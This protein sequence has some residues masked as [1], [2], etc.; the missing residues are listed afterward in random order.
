LAV[1]DL[2]VGIGISRAQG[3]NL[4]GLRESLTAAADAGLDFVSFGDHVSFHTGAGTD[5]L[6]TATALAMLHPTPTPPIPI[7]VGGRSD[8]AVRRAGRFAEG[9]LG[10]WSSPRRFAEAVAL[11]EATAAAAGRQDVAWQHG[12]QFWCGIDDSRESARARLAAAMQHSY[13]LPFE[14]FERYCPYGRPAD[15]AEYLAL[16]LESGCTRFNLGPI[17]PDPA[18]AI[19]G[20]AEVKRLLVGG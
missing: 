16:Y 8:A 19:A 6:I 1:V 2:Q 20:A 17:A 9:W 13:Q 18:T 14:R 15:L 5:G 3:G 4:D 7:L 10:I 12:M 11:A